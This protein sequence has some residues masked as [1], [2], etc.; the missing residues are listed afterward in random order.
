MWEPT[1]S[2]MGACLNLARCRGI[3]DKV[4]SH[5]V[6]VTSPAAAGS[7]TGSAPTKT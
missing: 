5:Q 3:A 6:A 4:G 1:L 2:A 7:P